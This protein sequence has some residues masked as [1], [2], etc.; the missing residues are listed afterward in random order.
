MTTPTFRVNLQYNPSSDSFWVRAQN[1]K[2]DCLMKG[3]LTKNTVYSQSCHRFFFEE[4]KSRP[5][6]RQKMEE[7]SLKLFAQDKQ[8]KQLGFSYVFSENTSVSR[9]EALIH[10]ITSVFENYYHNKPN[11]KSFR[12]IGQNVWLL[13]T[14]K[15]PLYDPKKSRDQTSLNTLRDFQDSP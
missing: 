12:E 6:S 15:N 5:S 8:V 3:S 2:D 14:E 10:D 13:V 11:I 1:S 4:K 9:N 7:P